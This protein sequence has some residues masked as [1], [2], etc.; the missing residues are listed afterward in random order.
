M[1][2]ILFHALHSRDGF[3]CHRKKYELGIFCNISHSKMIFPLLNSLFIFT[4]YLNVSTMRCKRN[5]LIENEF[6][7]EFYNFSTFIVTICNSLVFTLFSFG[8]CYYNSSTIYN[9]NIFRL[10]N[11]NHPPRV[12]NC[13]E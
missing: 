5:N 6:S 2:K 10:P 9:L 8:R 7:L 3:V 13:D 12:H 1:K 4:T 11:K